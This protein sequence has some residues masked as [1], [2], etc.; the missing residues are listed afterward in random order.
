MTA[1][2]TKKWTLIIS[3]GGNMP[4][5]WP[6]LL[7]HKQYTKIQLPR[8]KMIKNH[9]DKR[10][11]LGLSQCKKEQLAKNFILNFQNAYNTLS[12][13]DRKRRYLGIISKTGP[14]MFW[15]KKIGRRKREVWCIVIH[16][17]EGERKVLHMKSYDLPKE[18]LAIIGRTL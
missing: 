15:K 18:S 12:S 4:K 6:F 11:P 2:A 9:Y 10:K 1:Y 14:K 17:K 7:I 16:P 3:F 8:R 5:R 13:S